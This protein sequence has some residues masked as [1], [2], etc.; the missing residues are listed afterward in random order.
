MSKNP[1]SPMKNSFSLLPPDRLVLINTGLLL[2]VNLILVVTSGNALWAVFS[3]AGIALFIIYRLHTQS[4]QAVLEQIK[5][6]ATHLRKGKLEYR[7]TT[8]PSGSRFHELAWNLNDTV[9][10]FETFM[11]EVDALFKAGSDERYYRHALTRGMVGRFSSL[12][13]SFESSTEA[14]QEIHWQQKMNALHSKLGHLKTANLLKNLGQTQRDLNDI[15]N[16]MEEIEE[17]SNTSSNS[18][19]ESLQSVRKVLVDLN[20]II[21]KSLA[22]RNSTEK[23]AEDSARIAEMTTVITSV[24]E[25]TNLLALNAAIEAARAGEHGRG[26]AVVADEVK[27]LANRTKTAALDIDR[28]MKEFIAST[29]SMVTNSEQMNQVSEQ[30]KSAIGQF[31]SNF[32]KVARNSQQ[33]YNKVSYVQTVCQISLTKID[34]LIYMQRA[35]HAVEQINPSKEETAPVMVGADA[36]RFGKWYDSGYGHRRYSHLPVYDLIKVPHVAVHGWVHAAIGHL[37]PGWT[38]VD[39]RHE[40]ILSAFEHAEKSSAQLLELVERMGE[41]K[42]RFESTAS[43]SSEMDVE[44]F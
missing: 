26:F 4:E 19:T 14:Q 41:E 15:S 36:C 21:E 18:A 37:E 13:E 1:V 16:Q 38:K 29:N 40:G 35:Y 10:Q 6:M 32:E 23:L 8:I 31:E 44:M 24:S 2:V 39:A 11:R 20:E 33:V 3:P 30:S 34:H 25:Q 12:L 28:I 42:L 22:M 27:A 43:D 9:D 17:Y 5:T 7:I